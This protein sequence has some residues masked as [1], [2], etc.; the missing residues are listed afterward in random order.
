MEYTILL[1]DDEDINFS[2]IRDKLRNFKLGKI[3]LK[4]ALD[5]TKVLDKV[6]EHRPDLILLD[7]NFKNSKL[8]G[9]DILKKL[10]AT[11][12]SK[13]IPII[14]LTAEA[15][16]NKIKEAFDN[17]IAD[18]ISKSASAVVIQ[19]RIKAVLELNEAKKEL[20]KLLS[21][22]YPIDIAHELKEYGYVKPRFYPCANVMV[23]DFKNFS[24]I[25]KAVKPDELINK[26]N[27]YFE[28]FDSIISKYG[29]EKIKTHKDNYICGNGLVADSSLIQKTEQALNIILAGMEVQQ[30]MQDQK[31]TDDDTWECDIGIS[32]GNLIA[33]V[34]GQQRR[35]YDIWGEAFIVANQIEKYG[36][37]DKVAISG[38]TYEF[39]KDFFDFEVGHDVDIKGNIIKNYLIKR[40]KPK[41]AETSG[42]P[43]EEFW[44]LL[45]DKKNIS[46]KYLTDL[47]DSWEIHSF[48]AEIDKKQVKDAQLSQL[49]KEFIA[50]TRDFDYADRLKTWI[51][52]AEYFE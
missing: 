29:I 28:E 3:L 26:I 40:V 25:S 41:Y 17:D 22:T 30:F 32:S 5:G 31:K 1:A 47:I 23:I 6:K 39:V 52:S 51:N 19:A 33:G 10:K 48:F 27:V 45:K 14:M 44:N 9:L 12:F 16:D 38:T 7:W 35:N 50:G 24:I 11:S 13:D 46:K 34:L 49:R 36:E 18:F 20:E 21:C 4:I 8:T 37:I 42:E 15:D 43:N 2:I